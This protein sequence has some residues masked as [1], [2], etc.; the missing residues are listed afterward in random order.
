MIGTN[1]PPPK[2]VMTGR[3]PRDMGSWHLREVLPHESPWALLTSTSGKRVPRITLEGHKDQPGVQY[4]WMSCDIFRL[5]LGR[6]GF[7]D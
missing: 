7:V 4:G 2:P 3:E 6:R 1:L 5:I